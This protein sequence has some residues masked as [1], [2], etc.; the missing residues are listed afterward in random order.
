MRLEFK[1]TGLK[2]GETMNRHFINSRVSEAGMAKYF[3]DS[4]FF[5]P[6]S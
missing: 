5:S 3:D 2:P 6:G 1:I 4:H